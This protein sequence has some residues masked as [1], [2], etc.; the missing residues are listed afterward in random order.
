[1]ERRFHKIECDWKKKKLAVTFILFILNRMT[2]VTRTTKK[3][4]VTVAVFRNLVI[5]LELTT[6]VLTTFVLTT[7]VLTTF[8]L[9]TFVLTTFAL[10][11]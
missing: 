2:F 5:I 1:M 4:V 11:I 6:F 3:I 9:T 10:K 7:F 8:V